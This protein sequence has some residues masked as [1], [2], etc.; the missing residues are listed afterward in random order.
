LAQAWLKQFLTE[1][2][3]LTV[4]FVVSL[5]ISAKQNDSSSRSR[6]SDVEAPGHE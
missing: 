2:Q 5:V 6:L 4:R 1:I 3:I